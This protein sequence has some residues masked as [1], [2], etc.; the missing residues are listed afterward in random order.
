NTSWA[1]IPD[2]CLKPSNLNAGCG[3]WVFAIKV[4]KVA[5]C[6]S[7]DSSNWDIFA[8][9]WDSQ[10]STGE[11]YTRDREVL[12]YGEI[13]TSAQAEFGS[14]TPGTGFEDNVNE[15]NS[16]SVT[17]IANGDYD[18]K[19]KSSPSWNG[20]GK[21]ATF[22][23]S[24][25]CNNPQEFSL[26][27]FKEDTFSKAVQVDTIGVSIDATGTRTEEDGNTVATNTL[28]LKV[29]SVFSSDTYSGTITYIIAE[30]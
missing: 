7:A 22:D 20:H 14:V 17:Y 18:Q 6:S 25:N 28:W 4:G 26:K 27:A 21:V 29:S 10:D 11:L 2:D 16:I 5:A 8:K 1:I 23:A 9:A 24:G 12:W 19:V 3:D 30:R 13:L 15:V